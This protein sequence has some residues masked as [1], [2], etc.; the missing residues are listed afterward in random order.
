MKKLIYIAGL[1]L[2]M[3]LTSC[4]DFLT[5]ESPDQLT[6]SSFWRDVDD[7]EAAMASVYA[8]LYHGDSY[9][10]SEVRWPV[11]EYRTDLYDMGTDAINYQ[12][13]TDLYKFT[14]TN[15][16]TQFS[17]YYQDL[18]RGINFANQVLEFTPGIPEGS[19]T[20]A[21]RSELIAEAHFMR[22]YYHLMLLLNWEKIIIRDVYITTE[23][24]LNKPLSDRT[25]C[26]DFV[27]DELR[28]GTSLPT[29]SERAAAD[30][31]GRATTG[32]AN[33]YLGF[34]YLTRAYEEPANESEYLA[35]AL[36]AL[37]DVQGY[38]LVGGD[39]LINMFNGYNKNSKESI[40]EVQYSLTTDNGARYYSYM[41]WFILCSEL[42]GWDEILPNEKLMNEFKKEGKMSLSGMYDERLYNTCYF[43][44]D[45][46]N[47]GT[48]RIYGY[49]YDDIFYNWATN[50]SGEYVDADGNIISSDELETK[51][52]KNVYDAPSFRR[53]TPANVDDYGTSRCAYN[54]PLMRYA[55]VLLMKAEALN[56]QGHPDQAIPLI[57]QVRNVHGNMPAMTGIT[58]SE[59]QKQIEHERIIEFPLESYRWYDLRRWGQL[60]EALGSRGFVESKHSFFPI[61]LWEVNANDRLNETDDGI[62]E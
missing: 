43:N 30:E 62:K 50:A 27:I 6:T 3:G 53:F 61:P 8:Q 9:A 29:A 32:A 7:A 24:G 1:F 33:A 34:A 17:Y 42:G 44:D 15:G 23:D 28:Q 59:V 58:Q 45:Y 38:E 14:W 49:D 12:N 19:I 60:S 5:V 52:V 51:G 55:N 11:E 26:W 47:D 22:G 13:W 41:Q 10:T 18:Y 21:K 16:N 20:E 2:A 31:T 4:D 54:I 48:G 36:S 56:K 37:N 39:D 25:A 35:A 57:N 46:Y 40:F